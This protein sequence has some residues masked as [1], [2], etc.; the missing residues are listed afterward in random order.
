ML[1]NPTITYSNSFNRACPLKYPFFNTLF[2]NIRSLRNRLSDLTDYVSH[3]PITLHLVILN[4]TWLSKSDVK[5]FN[6]PGYSSFHSV[7]D[8]TGGGVAIFVKNSFARAN[9]VLDIVFENSN[10]LVLHLENIDLHICTIYKPPAPNL[11]AELRNFLPQLDSVLSQF[12]KLFVFGD[13]NVNL[14]DFED[15]RVKSY[16]STVEVN[17]FKFL[18][19]YDLAHYTRRDPSRGSLTCIDHVFT[20]RFLDYNFHFELESI[21]NSDHRAILLRTH[22]LAPFRQKSLGKLLS[23]EKVDHQKILDSNLLQLENVESFDEMLKVFSSVVAENTIRTVVREKFKKPFMNMDIFNLMAIRHNY[24]FALKKFPNSQLLIGRLKYY[25]NRVVSE[26]RNAKCRLATTELR[27]NLGNGRKTWQVLNNLC[28]NRSSA[29]NDSCTRLLI[30]NKPIT[31]GVDIAAAFNRHFVTVAHE[32][33]SR[34]SLLPAQTFTFPSAIRCSFEDRPVT[35]TEINNI[36]VGLSN[37]DALDEYGMSNKILKIHKNA[38]SGPLARLVTASM[39]EGVFPDILKSA[40]VKPLH[41]AGDKTDMNNY[42][43]IA[44]EL[45]L[46]K[47]FEAVFVVRWQ[48]HL[49]TNEIISASQF[50][51]VEKSN[52]E[53]ALVHL[54]S[55]VYNNLE[56]CKFTAA[57]FID[58]SKAFDC[59][60]HGCLVD[61]LAT[62]EL[63][64]NYLSLFGSYCDNRSQFVVNN[65]YKSDKLN[66]TTGVFQGSLFGPKAFI[67]Y[68]NDIFRLNLRGHLFLYA[69]DTSIVYGEDSLQD[70]RAAIQHDLALISNF[71]RSLFLEINASKTKYVLFFG[72]KRFENFTELNLRIVLDGLPVERVANY[73]VLGLF[74]DELLNFEAHINVIYNKCVSMVYALKRIRS[75]ITTKLAY[76]MYFAHIYSHLF[77]VNPLWSVGSRDS[78]NRLFLLQKKVLRI[79]QNKPPL[80]PSIDLF[81]E[82]VLPLLVVNEF[83]LLVLAFKIKHNLI[84][85]NITLQYVRDIHSHGT[86]HSL[87][88]NFYVLR[89]ESKYGIAD[90]YRRG[91]ILYNELPD[92]VKRY[93]RL[94][95]FKTRLREY[96]YERYVAETVRI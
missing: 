47:V 6:L 73:K 61:K 21:L 81:S 13:L 70:L 11:S 15:Q 80:S 82:K 43:P 53:I 79:I 95:L 35:A 65:S 2:L 18:N 39:S 69:D 23:F 52:T 16:S 54:L 31:N 93:S 1:D 17:G 46:A 90:F 42:R 4:E 28:Y 71:F 94:S 14:F 3:S 86:R 30:N 66:V 37:S 49:I 58:I 64:K 27:E 22:K 89:H 25:R 67:Y 45:I 40:I 32:I 75:Q 9:P 26:V 72:R 5:Y 83:C 88:D 56:A 96:L 76:Q 68:I 8:K 87:S 10:F 19:S 24:E 59:V 48:N 29:P 44:I 41:K 91:L 62:L 77:F 36:I 38:F 12:E 85:N 84:K 92:E 20:N 33:H 34:I 63:P 74:I 50:G 57:V 60:H 51:F 7:R 78:V 55:D